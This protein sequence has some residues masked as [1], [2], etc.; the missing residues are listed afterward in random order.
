MD[1]KTEQICME[2]ISYAGNGKGIASDAFRA[3]MKDDIEEAKVKLKEAGEEIGKAH[4][5]QTEL[6]RAELNGKKVEKTILL[7][8]AQDQFMSALTFRDMVKMMIQMYERLT[9]K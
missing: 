8:H 9:T 4:N 3:L 2:L 7:I 6:M 5:I 1:E